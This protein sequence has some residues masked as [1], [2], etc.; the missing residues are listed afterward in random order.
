MTDEKRPTCMTCD[1]RQALKLGA[2]AAASFALAGA[3]LPGCG[4]GASGLSEDVILPLADYP[5]LMQANSFV[6]VTPSTS[7]FDFPLFVRNNGDGSY[8][9]L[10]G[11]CPHLSCAVALR[12]D[13]FVCPCHDS[14]FTLDGAVT[15]GPARQDLPTIPAELVDDAVVLRAGG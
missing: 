14:R 9:A 12:Q 6:E 15:Q 7:G 4:G 8:L 13:E 2:S 1:R 10:S 3:A 5:G 11:E